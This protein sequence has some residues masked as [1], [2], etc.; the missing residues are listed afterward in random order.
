[1]DRFGYSRFTAFFDRTLETSV[2]QSSMMSGLYYHPPRSGHVQAT[3]H[4]FRWRRVQTTAWVYSK[5]SLLDAVHLLQFLRAGNSSDDGRLAHVC[6][7]MDAAVKAAGH[8]FFF[9]FLTLP[10]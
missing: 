7:Q 8:N 2:T 4:L 6:K 1:M 5:R 10:M 3:R 9:P